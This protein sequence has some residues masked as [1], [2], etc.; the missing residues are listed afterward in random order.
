MKG[1]VLPGILSVVLALV[2]MSTTALA[3]P[4]DLYLTASAP[5]SGAIF[6]FTPGG[7]KSTFATTPNS[8]FGIAVDG[9][10]NV[11]QADLV[12]INKYSSSGVPTLF[13]YATGEEL[14]FDANGNLFVADFAGSAIYKIT[15]AGVVSVFAS[16]LNKPVGLEF[17][18]SGN[19]F[20]SDYGSGNLYKFTPSGVRSTFATGLFQPACLT[21][22]ATDN[23]FVAEFKA[24]GSIYEY[25]P[26]GVQSTFASGLNRP[27]GLAFDEAG[28]LF[29][30]DFGSGK[31]LKFT[32]G[33]AQSTFA[34]G[35]SQP[36]FLAFQPVP[37]PS[38]FVLLVLGIAS[39]TFV[40]YRRRIH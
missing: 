26:A 17:D 23:L 4:G 40:R 28:N 5:T 18:S 14:A 9:G 30:T 15:P 7:T 12:S 37:E 38:T 11:Y 25:T 1:R 16:G 3:N 2:V 21:V 39:L 29:E 13:S 31:I 20:S 33:G 19:L 34:T 32:P 10:G 36:S 24:G 8:N 22:D 27:W 35:I 6:R